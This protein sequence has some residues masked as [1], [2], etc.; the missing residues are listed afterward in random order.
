MSESIN[1]LQEFMIQSKGTV[2]LLAIGFLI[3]FTAF[4]KYL[5]GRKGDPD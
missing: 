3:G 4:W 1:T 2:Y 5:N